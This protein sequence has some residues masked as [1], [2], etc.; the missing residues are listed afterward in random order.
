MWQ[1]INDCGKQVNIGYRIRQNIRAEDVYVTEYKIHEFET[2]KY[3]LHLISKSK[4]GVEAPV[5]PNEVIVLTCEQIL[6][7]QFEVW[8]EKED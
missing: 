8:T 2:D 7:Y 3:K 6:Q 5:D 1:L 4:N